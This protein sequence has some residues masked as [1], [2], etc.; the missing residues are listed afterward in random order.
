MAAR[1]EVRVESG[2]E[3]FP[4]GEWDA[5]NHRAYPFL[6]HAFLHAAE[7]TG[8]VSTASGWQPCHLAVRGDDGRLV[9][10]MPLYEKTHSFG[11]FVF[12]WAWARAYAQAGFDYYPKLVSAVPFTPAT[13]PRLLSAPRH[14][15]LYETA[16]LQ[17]TKDL[18]AERELSS[19]HVQFPLGGDIAALQSAGFALREDC[20]F[21]WHNRGYGSFDDFLARFSSRKRKNARRDRRL[22][23]DQG[24]RFRWLHGPDMDDE[25]WRAVFAMI[26]R[27]FLQ[28]GGLPYFSLAFF[29]SVAA[30]QPET[31]LVI[32]GEHHGRPAAAAVFFVGP[33]TLYGRYWGSAGD[34]D[35]LHFETCYYQG[36]EYCIRHGLSTFEPGTQGEHKISRGFLPT[37]TSSAHWLAHPQFFDAIADY[38]DEE[39]AHVD[40]YRQAVDA[41]SPYRR[42][43]STPP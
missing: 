5:L 23:Q 10:A 4:A 9:A 16:L 18:A 29:K 20:Q 34:Y 11:E 19:V 43:E 35:A 37:I 12:D 6:T 32:L 17:R 25:L 33:E 39:R 2:M 38:L 7:T 14:A 30:A 42:E 27:T 21:H 15:G 8:C 1:P 22:V 31:L 36:I 28:R 24:I 13:S 40:R 3:A 26:T 41:H